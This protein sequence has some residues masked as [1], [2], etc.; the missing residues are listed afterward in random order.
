[1]NDLTAAKAAWLKLTVHERSDF[2]AFQASEGL[3]VALFDAGYLVEGNG[4]ISVLEDGTTRRDN[5]VGCFDFYTVPPFDDPYRSTDL[6]EYA[7]RCN[8]A[9][10]NLN[11]GGTA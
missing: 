7:K 2:V 6:L 5:E 4:D 9:Y 1:M 10:A 8:A 11:Q 3:T